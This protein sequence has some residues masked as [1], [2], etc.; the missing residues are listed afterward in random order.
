MEVE[1]NIIAS[2]TRPDHTEK[3]L[4]WNQKEEHKSKNPEDVKK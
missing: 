1:G 2:G 3:F 4:H